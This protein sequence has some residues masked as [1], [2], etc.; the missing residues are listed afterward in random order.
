[1]G[2]LVRFRL[3]GVL[4]EV[5]RA[6]AILAENIISR[7]KVL[8]GL[9]T[10]RNDIPQEGRMQP[11]P[12]YVEQVLDQRVAVFP[13]IYGQRAVVRLFYQQAGLGSLGELGLSRAVTLT[14]EEIV[15]RQQGLLLLTGPAGSGKS[16]TLAA[17]LRRIVREYPG[18]S[19][20]ALEDPVERRI[21]GVTQVQ[22]QPY[23]ELT[24]PRALRSL[25]RQDPQVLMIGEIR[26]AETARI[27]TEAALTGHLLLSTL[28]SGTSAGAL[29]RLLEMGIEPYQITSTVLAIVNQRLV[30]RLCAA[31]KEPVARAGRYVSRGCPQCL[32]TGFQGRTPVAELA[33]LDSE[34]REAILE[35]A[36]LER[37]EVLLGEQ[38]YEDLHQD[39]LRLVEEGVTSLEEVEQACGRR[40]QA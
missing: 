5:E 19:I 29:L 18:K 4:Q 36:D 35:G 37:L 3:D 12:E 34:L 6:P 40:R 21:E 2:L 13:T 1:V 16:T 23:G 8:G 38:G 33:T 7:L 22:I 28:H 14:L 30:R 11:L 15:G 31:C 32:G 39:G 27:A 26:D 20:V 9:L 25:L 10:Y 17:M 24:F